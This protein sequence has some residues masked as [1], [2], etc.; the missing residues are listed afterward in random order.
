MSNDEAFRRCIEKLRSRIFNFS[1]RNKELYFK[2]SRSESTNL[3]ANLLETATIKNEILERTSEEDFHVHIGKYDGLNTGSAKFE[4]LFCTGELVLSDHFMFRS[5]PSP[6]LSKRIERLRVFDSRYQREYGI[7]GG[8]LLGPFIC[9]RPGQSYQRSDM[10]I[11][12]ILKLPI[13]I[14]KS[15]RK[16]VLLAL[17]STDKTTNCSLRLFLKESRGLDLPEVFDREDGAKNLLDEIRAVFAKAQLKEITGPTLDRVPESPKKSRMNVDADGNESRVKVTLEESLGKTDL[18]LYSRM[19]GNEFMI[20]DCYYLDKLG[21]SKAALIGDYD[22]ILNSGYDHPVLNQLISGQSTP[23]KRE[24]SVPGAELNRYEEKECCFVVETNCS[25]HRAMDRVKKSDAIVIQGPPGTGKSQTITNI[26]ADSIRRG[27]R[28]LFVSEKRAALDVVFSRLQNAA[29]AEHA[30]LIHSSDMKPSLLYQEFLKQT[31]TLGSEEDI[32]AWEKSCSKIDHMKHEIQEPLSNL[33]RKHKSGLLISDILAE[34]GNIEPSSVLEFGRM[35]SNLSFDK[36]KEI[37]ALLDEVEGLFERVQDFPSNPWRRKHQGV[38]ATKNL[39]EEIRILSEKLDS[40]ARCFND[41]R[42]H[43]GVQVE[44]ADPDFLGAIRALGVFDSRTFEELCT[45]IEPP[46]NSMSVQSLATTLETCRKY[47]QHWTTFRQDADHALVKECFDY[48]KYPRGFMA[49]FTPSFWR[50]RRIASTLLEGGDTLKDAGLYRSWLRLEEDLSQAFGAL[51]SSVREFIL[52]AEDRADSLGRVKEFVD[53][54]A[55]I[56]AHSD[57]ARPRKEVLK[58]IWSASASLL[59]NHDEFKACKAEIRRYVESD[60]E[61]VDEIAELA[62]ALHHTHAD[63]DIIDK[64]Q[65]KVEAIEE[66][67]GTNK[68]LDTFAE[69]L[70]TRKDW[71]RQLVKEVLTVWT[72]SIK[73]DEKGIR[74]FDSNAHID[75][76]QRFRNQIGVH[77]NLSRRA[78]DAEVARFQQTSHGALAILEKEAKKKRKVKSPREVMEAGALETMLSLKPCW[79][80][81][82]LSISQTLPNRSCLFDLVVFDEASQ[83]KVEDALPSVY[84]AKKLVVVG[85]DKQMPPT[86][87]FSLSHE[88]DDEDEGFEVAESILDMASMVYPTEMLEWHYRSRSEALIAFSNRAFYGGRLIA[89]PNPGALGSDGSITFRRNYGYFT[90]SGNAEEARVVVDFLV[91]KL[92]E[93]PERSIG[94]IAMGVSQQKAIEKEIDERRGDETFRKALEINEGLIIEGAYAGIF[95]KNLENVQGDEREEII[96]SVGYAPPGEG[97]R[98]R[99]AFGP[100]SLKGGGRRLNVAITRAK[101]RVDVFCSFDPSE[102]QTDA[103]AWAKNPDTVYF[104][105]YLKFTKAVSDGKIDIAKSILGSFGMGGVRTRRSPTRFNLHVKRELESLGYR[106]AT[107][108]GTCGYFIDL[109]IEDPVNAN[110]FVLGIECDGAVFH[111]TE[112]ARDRDRAR[113]KLLES[114]GWRIHRIWSTDWSLRKDEEIQKIVDLLQ[115]IEGQLKRAS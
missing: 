54:T 61:A 93:N 28:V 24:P 72:H 12:P 49:Y 101:A 27:K 70:A 109:A 90:S 95:I 86:N 96:I 17:E 79:L 36:L 85:D 98:M 2:P 63:V 104:G 20:V 19:G 97:K 91:D 58:S 41:S 88:D 35:F 115:T 25:Q 6:T 33:S 29:I 3:T 48:F 8:W 21:A 60:S 111:S 66:K 64:I 80:M 113:Q 65:L 40:I 87:F 56:L 103:D 71:G 67:L 45:F 92:I 74:S 106:V 37:S 43:S 112:Y 84:R 9:I 51:W 34:Y 38:F 100:L 94:V 50:Y 39:G 59:E 78:V 18:D 57:D 4:K 68:L 30:A 108:I 75:R 31:D 105:R 47:F 16:D 83:V 46:D 69:K 76:L 52:S 99:K 44:I 81:S 15:K 32:Q 13:N 73:G 11:A 62:R 23:E 102:I 89:V 107:E 110:A 42:S 7:S 5:L 22:D 55:R 10:V 1:R 114:R 14:R 82:P 53:I 77:H 26:I